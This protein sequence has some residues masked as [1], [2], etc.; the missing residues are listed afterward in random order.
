[1]ATKKQSA[2]NEETEKI[3]S[4]TVKPAGRTAASRKT[5]SKK[6]TEEKKVE[7]VPAVESEPS[8]KSA[9]RK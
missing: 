2:K 7:A 6:K 4:E 1:M 3:V 5:A 9:A 8:R